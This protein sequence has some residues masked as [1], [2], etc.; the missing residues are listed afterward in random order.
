MLNRKIS[1][2]FKSQSAFSKLSSDITLQL[3][4]RALDLLIPTHTHTVRTAKVWNH[5]YICAPDE[6]LLSLMH[7]AFSL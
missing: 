3:R 7:L 1:K 4:M 6:S 2:S 5:L